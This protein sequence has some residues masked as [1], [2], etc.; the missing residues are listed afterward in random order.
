MGRLFIKADGQWWQTNGA[1]SLCHVGPFPPQDAS[2]QF[3]EQQGRTWFR[4]TDARNFIY[5]DEP[6]AQG[7]PGWYQNTVD[8]DFELA[9][10]P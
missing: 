2:G 6:A 4:T 9:Q 5:V 3:L 1:E 7:E 10:G 8:T